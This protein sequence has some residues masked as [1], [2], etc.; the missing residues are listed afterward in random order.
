MNDITVVIRSIL[1][2]PTPANVAQVTK[3]TENKLK[4]LNA[5]T[6]KV[7]K[8]MKEATVQTN[9]F[10]QSVFDAGKFLAP[11]CSNT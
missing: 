3:N 7:A 6:S 4:G 8:N 11:L 5:E 10:G 2:D 9:L 1:Q